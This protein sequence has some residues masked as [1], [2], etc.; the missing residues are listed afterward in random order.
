VGGNRIEP[1][2]TEE[3][4]KRQV[5]HIDFN[6]ARMQ[7]TVHPAS[8]SDAGTRKVGIL[9]TNPGLLPRSARGDLATKFADTFAEWGY[10]CFRF[11]LPGLGD[12]S[13]E[14]PVEVLGYY[15]QVQT[16]YYAE[17]TLKMAHALC[18]QHRL[19]GMILF[20]HCGSATTAAFAKLK[21]QSDIVKGLILLDPSFILYQPVAPAP[22]KAATLKPQAQPAPGKKSV[23]HRIQGFRQKFVTTK[24]GFALKTGWRKTKKFFLK[25]R[26]TVLPKNSNLAVINA[27]LEFAREQ[28][29][30]LAF[31]A[32]RGDRVIAFDYLR[33]LQAKS[34]G[35][36]RYTSVTGTN[37]SFVEGLGP[38]AICIGVRAFLDRHFSPTIQREKKQSER[39]QQP[40]AV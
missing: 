10:P 9:F 38:E 34:K 14:V 32:D 13:G 25:M 31:H 20:G 18:D 36:I 23:K 6:G 30:M 15:E 24:F 3:V 28:V 12:S 17:A 26:G 39:E 11:D 35:A 21:D 37:H 4:M 33:Y 5:C 40:L 19:S 22:P 2:S 16:G 29:P 1:Y 7:G 27:W 8:E